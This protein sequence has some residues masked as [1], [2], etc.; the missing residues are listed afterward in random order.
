VTAANVA[1][2]AFN[3]GNSGGSDTLWAPLQLNDG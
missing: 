1:N 3:T 2:T